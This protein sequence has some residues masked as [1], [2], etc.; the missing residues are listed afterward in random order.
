MTPIEKIWQHIGRHPRHGIDVPLAA[1]HTKQS[2][3]IGEF[4]DLLP[5]IDWC[6]SLGLEVIQL[7]PLNDSGIDPSPYNALSSC[8]LHPLYLSLHA[9][10]L[11]EELE[12]ALPALQRLTQEQ[13]IPYNEVLSQKLAWLH[14]YYDKQ[15][16]HFLAQP[17][18]QTFVA[19]N[20]WLTPYADFKGERAFH[21]VVQY[22]CY[23]QMRHVKE[24]ASSKGILLQGDIPILVNPHSVDVVHHKELFDTSVAAGAPPDI[25]NQEGQYW[26]FPL[27]KWENEKLEDYRWWRERL[28]YAAHFYDLYRIDHVVGFF[29]IWAI[30]LNHLPKEGKFVPEDS[31]LWIPRGKE[32][33][34][35]LLTF[36]A[37][38]PIAEDLGAVPP[39]V[40]AC[41]TELGICGTKVMRWERIWNE[42]QQFIPIQ[43][44]PELSLTT[45][46]THD[47]P[48]LELWWRDN[49]EEAKAYASSRQWEYQPKLTLEQRQAI[50]KESHHTPSLFH[51]NLLQEYLA[52]FPE[53]VWPNPEDERINTPGKVLP[54]N[55]VYRLRPSLE[56]L[57]A[58]EP[59]KT[60]MRALIA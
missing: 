28:H 40:R 46:S 59:L 48:T 18:F 56:A 25:Y 52:C 39:E 49:P 26:G 55:W 10:D 13:K 44:Y 21:Q 1:L 23:L 2:C 50:L 38:L 15:G 34:Q 58:H 31:S 14:L 51:I 9:L 12:D 36:S 8:A 6:Q 35:K 60:L 45:V 11:D 20:E 57:Q 27:F 33:L 3:G 16:A 17:A 22:L 43:D 24:Y 54:T 37:M 19:E 41:L 7:L 29:R 42:N 5:L 4:W 53:L 47:S 32:V 30:P